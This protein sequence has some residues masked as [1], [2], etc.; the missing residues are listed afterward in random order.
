M[1]FESDALIYCMLAAIVAY[2][3]NGW[4]VGWR[5]LFRVPTNLSATGLADYGWYLL[6]GVAS[7][8]VATILPEAFYRVRD[9][10]AALPNSCMDQAW[11]SEV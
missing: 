9:A 4:F 5:P 10:F 6:L 8:I 2:A 7:G 11:L 3:L 1:D